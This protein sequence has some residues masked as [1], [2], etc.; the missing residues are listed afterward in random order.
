[1]AVDRDRFARLLDVVDQRCGHWLALQVEGGKIDLSSQESATLDLQ[2]LR[3]AQTLELNRADFDTAVEH[4]V[5]S[6]EQTVSGLL[7]QA[8]LRPSDI[9]SVFFTG[10]SSGVNLLRQ[11]IGALVPDAKHVEGD[12]FGSIGSG[13]AI[14]AARKFG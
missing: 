3:P 10:G 13:L 14:D 2:R 11:R 8:G 1:E 7:R 12:L 5:Q 4:L 6:V 9:D